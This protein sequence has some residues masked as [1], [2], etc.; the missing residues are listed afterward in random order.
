MGKIIV[1]KGADFSENAVSYNKS[2]NYALIKSSMGATSDDGM[3]VVSYGLRANVFI[4][5]SEVT[6]PNH[7]S[8]NSTPA[9]ANAWS[10]IPVPTGA[11][12]VS[13]SMTNTG[14]YYG[15]VLR[16]ANADEI[17]YDSGWKQGGN[18]IHVNLSSYA[19]AV[20]LT[21]TFKIGSAGTDAFTDETI[22]SVGWSI[23][24]FF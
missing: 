16:D 14:Y 18:N 17:L 22:E 3:Q 11:K 21:S 7:W 10:M 23:E 9:I 8:N 19:K 24:F 6:N 12:G 15:L 1:I 4:P 5:R 13:L 2:Y 20:Y